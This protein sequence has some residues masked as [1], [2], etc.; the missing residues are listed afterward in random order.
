MANP[1]K[2]NGHIRIANDIMDAIIRIRIPGESRQVLDFILRKTYGYGK[3][4]DRISLSQFVLATGMKKSNIVR[5]INKLCS[6]NIVIKKDTTYINIYRFNKDFDKWKPLSKRIPGVSKRITRGIKKDNLGVSKKSTTINNNTIN[7]NT[8]NNNNLLSELTDSFKTSINKANLKALL[9]NYSISQLLIAGYNWHYIYF[10]GRATR[11]EKER[12]YQYGKNK[13]KFIEFIDL[14][15]NHKD[16]KDKVQSE[17]DSF[18]KENK[19]SD[20]RTG[21]NDYVAKKLSPEESYKGDKEYLKRVEGGYKKDGYDNPLD[22]MINDQDK[23]N[24]TKIKMSVQDYE[25]T[26][27]IKKEGR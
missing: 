27:G 5:A 15:I 9:K 24:Y 4:E 19:P 12:L 6:M 26:N 13:T 16:T 14:W 18:E 20:L 22:G 25:L 8:I 7:N 17:R 1:Q 2:E 21:R 11:N 23:R 10:E 3:K